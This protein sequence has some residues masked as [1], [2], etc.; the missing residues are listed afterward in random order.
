MTPIRFF[1]LLICAPFWLLIAGE[2]SNLGGQATHYEPPLLTGS[3]SLDLDPVQG[4]NLGTVA[5]QF[6]LSGP[7]GAYLMA[8]DASGLYRVTARLALN[9]QTKTVEVFIGQPSMLDFDLGNACALTGWPGMETVI[10]MVTCINGNQSVSA[11]EER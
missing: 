5:G 8:L 6:S 3:V 9:S 11:T 4:A 10:E 2:G 1:F 7:G